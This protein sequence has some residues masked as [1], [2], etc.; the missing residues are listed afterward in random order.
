MTRLVREQAQQAP[1]ALDCDFRRD[2]LLFRF[3]F[4]FLLTLRLGFLFCCLVLRF[5]LILVALVVVV[6]VEGRRVAE[7]HLVVHVLFFLCGLHRKELERGVRKLRHLPWEPAQRHAAVNDCDGPHVGRLRVVRRLRQD[8]WGQVRI[9]AD[10]ALSPHNLRLERVL[11]DG[12]GPKVDDLDDALA[13]NDAVVELQVAVREAHL[14]KVREA[15]EDLLERATNLALR[16]LAGHYDCEKVK[17]TVLHHLVVLAVL[18]DNV[19][20]LNDVGVM[21]G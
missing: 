12:R 6:V 21:Q 20:R 19:Q 15:G 2:F 8:L 9:R 1:R 10:D 5:V 7:T 14:V 4:L 16:H 18:L 13:G 3:I 11:E 17:R